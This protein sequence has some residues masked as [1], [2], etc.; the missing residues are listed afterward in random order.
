[1]QGQVGTLWLTSSGTAYISQKFLMFPTFSYHFQHF[2]LFLFYFGHPVDLK[3]YLLVL[4]F[5]LTLH[6]CM[7]L[8]VLKNFF[9]EMCV[10]VLCSFPNWC[11]CFLIVD[12]LEFFIYSGYKLLTYNL[13]VSSSIQWVVW[14]SQLM[15]FE[16]QILNFL[17]KSNLYVFSFCGCAFGVTSKKSLLNSKSWRCIPVFF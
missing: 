13:W 17:M 16:G 7:W 3:W 6:I 10:Q 15:P 9:G 1:L 8:L 12:W 14:L 5:S 2:L 11:I 4:W